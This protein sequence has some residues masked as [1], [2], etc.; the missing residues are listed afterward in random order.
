MINLLAGNC[1]S[2]GKFDLY[3]TICLSAMSFSKFKEDAEVQVLLSSEVGAEGLDLQFCDAIV[4]YDLPWNPMVVEQRIGRIDR[5]GQKAPVVRSILMKRSDSSSIR[6]LTP[7][8][9][10]AVLPMPMPMNKADRSLLVIQSLA[11]SW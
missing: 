2:F 9:T 3:Q 8:R 5:F 1:I 6:S 11:L 10:V 4:N 7:E